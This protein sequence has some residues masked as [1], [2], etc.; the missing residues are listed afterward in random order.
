MSGVSYLALLKLAVPEIILVLTVLV[1]LAAD[2]LALRELEL[3]LRLLVGAM[4]SCVGCAVAIA[5]MVALPEHSNLFEGML[6]VNPLTQFVKVA[7]LAL[8]ISTILISADT[9]F[10]TH[11]GEYLA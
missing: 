6:V 11:V 4:I 9:D 1:V 7:L 2:L 10:T 3:R 8:T 5:W